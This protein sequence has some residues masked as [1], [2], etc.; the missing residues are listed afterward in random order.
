MKI[1]CKIKIQ[2]FSPLLERNLGSNK[3]LVFFFF[4]FTCKYIIRFQGKAS[5]LGHRKI[6]RK[7]GPK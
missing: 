6:H 7:N 3:R 1:T 2:K 5:K 4:F